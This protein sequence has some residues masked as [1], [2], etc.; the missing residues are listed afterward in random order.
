MKKWSHKEVKQFAQD[1]TKAFRAPLSRGSS[2]SEP[3]GATFSHPLAV[4]QRGD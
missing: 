1:V 4:R 2:L 3:L